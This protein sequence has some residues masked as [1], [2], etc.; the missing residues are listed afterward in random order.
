MHVVCCYAAIPLLRHRK[1]QRMSN[2]FLIKS[3]LLCSTIYEEK[4]KGKRHKTRI[5]LGIRS[6]QKSETNILVH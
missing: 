6:F 5:E 4:W 1:S 3:S 2:T